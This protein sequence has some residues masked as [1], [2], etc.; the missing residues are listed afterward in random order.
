MAVCL[1]AWWEHSTV[2]ESPVELRAALDLSH[3]RF[4]IMS[5]MAAVDQ[6]AVYSHLVAISSTGFYSLN[7]VGKRE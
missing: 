1:T 3:L 6:H 7:I 2:S 4:L 5:V